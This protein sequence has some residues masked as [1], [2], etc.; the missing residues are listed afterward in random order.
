VR[1]GS[2]GRRH[3]HGRIAGRR[4][5]DSDPPPPLLLPP[6]PA[7]V[8]RK[9]KANDLPATALQGKALGLDQWRVRAW[10]RNARASHNRLAYD[11]TDKVAPKL[12]SVPK[13]LRVL[14][15]PNSPP[16]KS[17]HLQSTFNPWVCKFH[18]RANRMARMGHTHIRTYARPSAP[19]GPWQI[20][21]RLMSTLAV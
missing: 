19:Y 15:R 17:A 10:A 1:D 16:P 9:A 11:Q 8:I 12:R 18:L 14:G 4:A 3:S 21:E 5:P 7:I 13:L 20:S 6:Q 2:T